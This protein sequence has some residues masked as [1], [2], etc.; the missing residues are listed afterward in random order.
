MESLLRK[1]F[2]TQLHAVSPSFLISQIAMLQ[3][4]WNKK[5]IQEV[6]V[7]ILNPTIGTQKAYISKYGGLSA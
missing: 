7:D 5:Y 1:Q 6:R 3:I 2:T 4:G